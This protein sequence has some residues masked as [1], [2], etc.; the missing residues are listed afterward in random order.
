MR[1]EL[2]KLGFTPYEADIYLALI[3]IGQTG[4]GEIIKKTGLHRNVVYDTLDKLM[5]KNLVFKVIRRKIS[6]FQVADPNRILAEQEANLE[7]AQRIIPDLAKRA[8]VRQEIIV[9]EGLEGFQNFSIGMLERMAPGTCL[10]VLGSIGN[11]WYELMGDKY[12]IYRKITQKK[13]IRWKMVNFE[14]DTDRDREA[15]KATGLVEVRTMPESY[16]APANMLVWED[17]IALQ[18]L[19]EPYSVVEIKNKFLAESYLNYFNM[20]WKIGKDV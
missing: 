1:D 7:R 10:Y 12:K 11:R 6:L 19:T 2:L 9:Y 15:I 14:E 3:D 4:A 5:A 13:K 16:K 18:T 17:K 8:E 20:L